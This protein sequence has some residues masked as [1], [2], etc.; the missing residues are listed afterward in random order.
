[1]CVCVC[2]C[3]S[4]GETDADK[5]QHFDGEIDVKDTIDDG[6]TEKQYT[7]VH[8]KQARGTHMMS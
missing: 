2:Y 7:V 3:I 1:V 8:D 5:I 6:V 4:E